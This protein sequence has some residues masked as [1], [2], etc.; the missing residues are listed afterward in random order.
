MA[1]VGRFLPLI[2]VIS[3]AL[4]CGESKKGGAANASSSAVVSPSPRERGE[5]VVLSIIDEL[6]WCDVNHRGLLIDLGTAR[7]TGTQVLEAA[8]PP[9]IAA[10]ERQ[11]ASWARLFD[12]ELRVTFFHPEPSPVF[13]S[14]RAVA[15]RARRASVSIDDVPIG[16]LSLQEGPSRHYATATTRSPLGVGR[17]ELVIRLGG[18]KGSDAE[19]YAELDWVRIGV[20]D[21]LKRTY[22]A[23]TDV[24]MSMPTASLANVPHRVLAVRAPTTLACSLR[25]PETARFRANIGMR[26]DGEASVRIALVRDGVGKQELGRFDVVGGGD[27]RWT[28]IDVSLAKFAGAVA[29]LEL[30]AYSTTGTGRL[31]FGDPTVVVP[32]RPVAVVP[33]ARAAIVIVLDGVE[34]S[35][36][37]PWR[38][39]P[40]PHAPNLKRLAESALVFDQHRSPSSRVSSAVATL[41][42]GLA[43]LTHGVLD[44]SARVPKTL[45]SIG[46]IARQ[47]SVR[48]SM[49]TG[50]PTTSAVFGFAAH[51][52]AFAAYP[53]NE[54]RAAT[55]PIDDAAVWLTEQ[56]AKPNPDRPMLAFVHARG[57]HPPWDITPDEADQLPPKNYTGAVRP[58]DSAQAVAALNGRF[59]ALAPPDE[60]RMRAMFFAAL[61]TQDAAIGALIR[62]LEEAGRWDSTLLVVTGDVASGRSSMFADGQPLSEA[63]L[64][65]PLYLHFPGG[66]YA[67]QRHAHPTDHADVT[68]TL[69]LALGLEPPAELGGRDLANVASGADDSGHMSVAYTDDAYSARWGGYVLHGRFD[70]RRPSFC[71]VLR[72]PTCRF[73]RS[74]HQ[75]IA[76]DAFTRRFV[77][78]HAA[79]P[80]P[81]PRE[82][83]QLDSE[84]AATLKVWGL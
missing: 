34:R 79:L 28:E 46:D 61:H 42:S 53:S 38:D 63:T 9:A 15:A 14:V 45:L 49:W 20:P 59:S 82:T 83:A 52:E 55:A 29:R 4:G 58:R 66:A 24:D 33:R 23:P 56:S 70:E 5:K 81:L 10:A 12:K 57:G 43:P 31:L 72:D 64:S 50:V 71:D 51:W 2:A 75:P 8:A 80:P 77:E 11:G 17:H 78:V 26:G 25:I 54:G 35:D 68:R 47:G 19:P 67:G 44:A 40:S 37:P 16:T 39:T 84:S 76:A 21:E 18:A 74:M 1:F 30:E 62:K 13:V 36:L 22:G 6:R 73:D 32:A 69:L 3:C 65:V 7:A 27:A 60:E 48:G 41:L